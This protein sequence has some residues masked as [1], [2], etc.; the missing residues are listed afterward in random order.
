LGLLFALFAILPSAA[1]AQTFSD[2]ASSAGVADAG[3]GQG[4][5]WGD[6]DG[7]GDQDFYLANNGTNKLYR[8]NGNG[9]F[10]DIASS[11]GVNASGNSRGAVW[12]DID[13]DGDLD[14]YVAINGANLLYRNNGN[15]TFTDI[16]SSAGVNDSGDGVGVAWGDFDKD[17]DLDLYLA[18]FGGTNR[19]YRNNGN[20]TFTDIASSAGVADTG[21]GYGV[22]WGDFDND[23]DLDLH[24]AKIGAANRLYQ[25]NG[26]STFTDIASSAGVADAGSGRSAAWG[27]ID[28]DGDLDLYVANSGSQDRLYRNNGNST[29]TDVASSEGTGETSNGATSAAWADYDGDG[30]LDLCVVNNS[31]SSAHKLYRNGGNSNRWLQVKLVGV[32]SNKNGIGARVTAMTGSTQQRRDV[33]GGGS[34][35]WAQGSLPVEFGFGGTT[36]VDSLVIRWPTGTTQT[37][38]SVATNQVLTVTEFA[39]PIFTF[40]SSTLAA[41][42]KIIFDTNRDGNFNVYTMSPDGTGLTQLTNNSATDDSPNWSPDGSKIVFSSARD[43]NLEIY[44]MNSDGS[45]QTRLTNA[46]GTDTAPAWSPDG[47]KIAFISYRDNSSGELYVMNSDGSSQTR[48]TNDSSIDAFPSWSPDGTKIVFGSGP[49]GSSKVYRINSDGTGQT[50]LTSGSVDGHPVYSPDG[51]KIA[52]YSDQGN[53]EVYVMNS[54]GS[55]QTRLTNVSGHDTAPS[56]SP[57]GTKIVFSTNRRHVSDLFYE[58][59][60]VQPDPAD[61]QL[62]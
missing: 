5:A 38:R 58:L 62:V 1:F 61:H 2:Q 28:N 25:N 15:S 14:L 59:G 24:V 31:T 30:D 9:T 37:V 55:G 19:L 29:F 45:S 3:T 21:N 41:N 36:T 13:S 18:N 20:S 26:N 51:T 52:Y 39:V 7:D 11:A 60:R 23:G 47:T 4:I 44:T 57:D 22:A 48:L 54:D 12:G 34:G 53:Y 40:S 8:N 50:Q 6:F 42:T 46:S 35:A 56:W 27:D 10:T 33:E 16:A 49:G 17:G 43:G 32:G